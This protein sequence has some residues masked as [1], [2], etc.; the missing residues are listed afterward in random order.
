MLVSLLAGLAPTLNEEGEEEKDERG[1]VVLR[2]EQVKRVLFEGKAGIVEHDVLA[3]E[4]HAMLGSLGAITGRDMRGDRHLPF[5]LEQGIES[6]LRDTEEDIPVVS[7][8]AMS[9]AQAQ[10]ALGPSH[11][12]S[13]V[14]LTPTEGTSPAGPGIRGGGGKGPWTDLD[15]FYEENDESE[16]ESE[17]SDEGQPGQDEDAGG[18]DEDEDDGEEEDDDEESDEAE[19]DR[20]DPPHRS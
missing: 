15:K 16:E 11:V 13:P 17:D 18:D 5:W 3:D 10:R 14:V 19:E 6:A 1:G 2:R 7:F 8:T 20:E 9:S 12:G 4:D